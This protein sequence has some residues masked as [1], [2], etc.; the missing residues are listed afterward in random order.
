[1]N[2]KTLVQIKKKHGAYKRLIE[3]TTGTNHI[4]HRQQCDKVK[5]M[6]RKSTKAFNKSIPDKVKSNPKAFWKH[7]NSKRKCKIKIGD[8]TADNGSIINS[9]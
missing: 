7:T 2:T 4:K 3:S 8:L 9:D 6:N 1:M 5:V